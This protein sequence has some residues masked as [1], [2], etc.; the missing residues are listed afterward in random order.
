MS[1][2]R[3]GD[4]VG[5]HDTSC[6]LETVLVSRYPGGRSSDVFTITIHPMLTGISRLDGHTA[7]KRLIKTPL[8]R[9]QTQIS[10]AEMET[11]TSAASACLFTHPAAAEQQ[12]NSFGGKSQ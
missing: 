1:E 3:R 9:L 11:V 8:V 5:K 12:F 7:L 4:T 10:R 2:L 6:L